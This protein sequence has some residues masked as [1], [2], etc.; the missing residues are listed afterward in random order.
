MA[1][2]SKVPIGGSICP[3][4]N[5]TEEVATA[6]NLIRDLVSV[7]SKTSFEL[8]IKLFCKRYYQTFTLN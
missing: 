3:L 4:E 8:S 1:L 2:Q 6:F 7:Q 5:P